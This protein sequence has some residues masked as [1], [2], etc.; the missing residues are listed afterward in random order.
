MKYLRGFNIIELMIVLAI[1]GILS[2]I[3]IPS[4][5]NYV[6]KAKLVSG[7]ATLSS[8]RLAA[9]EKYLS[10]G[11]WPSSL[12]EISMIERDLLGKTFT[13]LEVGTDCNDFEEFCINAAVIKGVSTG[14]NGSLKVVADVS[15]GILDWKCKADGIDASNFAIWL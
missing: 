8:V 7:Y 12:H 10:S 11:T 3:A 6:N 15:S 2:S 4:Y 5:N 9:V 13:K 1:I 14:G